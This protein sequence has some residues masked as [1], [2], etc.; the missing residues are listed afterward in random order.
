[1]LSLSLLCSYTKI[2]W[3]FN[4]FRSEVIT[5]RVQR[6]CFWLVSGLVSGGLATYLYPPRVEASG[7]LSSER[8]SLETQRMK[9]GGYFKCWE[10]FCFS[11]FV[12]N[13][14]ILGKKH[15][16]SILTLSSVLK[17]A[18]KFKV[19]TFLPTGTK[20][21]HYWLVEWDMRFAVRFLLISL[22]P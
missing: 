15:L 7:D 4:V 21:E 12:D 8:L 14:S 2:F 16:S 5:T 11:Q 22:L 20:H 1:M 17:Y 3:K 18:R 9:A 19:S 6:I 10:L 13:S